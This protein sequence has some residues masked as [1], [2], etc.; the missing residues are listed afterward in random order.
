MRESGAP[1]RSEPEL[2]QRA[3][4]IAGRTLQQIAAE[5][6]MPVPVNLRRHKGWVGSLLERVLGTDAASLSEPDFTALGIE[7]KTLPIDRHG[8]PKESTFVCVA[9]LSARIGTWET[10]AVRRK[11]A[12]VL[13]VP[14]EAAADI[15]MPLRHIGSAILWSPS[16]DQERVLRADWEELSEMIAL[17]RLHEI[18]ARHGRCLQIRPKAANARALTASF[19]ESGE[20]SRTMP[21]GFYLRAKFTAE[22]I[23]GRGR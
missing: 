21:R 1:P 10:S 4:H 9:P 22:I 3:A 11:L 2:L 17:G 7:L 8:R 16:G 19:N 23:G 15:P 14:V 13:W 6:G 20:P 12:R 18:S 5:L